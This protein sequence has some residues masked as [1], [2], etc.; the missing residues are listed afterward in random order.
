MNAL[1]GKKVTQTANFLAFSF[2]IQGSIKDNTVRVSKQIKPKTFFQWGGGRFEVKACVYTFECC[3]AICSQF[4]PNIFR[5]KGHQMR[6]DRAFTWF[7]FRSYVSNETLQR[8]VDK[9]LSFLSSRSNASSTE[10]WNYNVEHY[11]EIGYFILY[12]NMC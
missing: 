10:N 9:Q 5:N 1:R 7:Q 3:H 8:E 12:L 4:I 11:F 2:I 6:E